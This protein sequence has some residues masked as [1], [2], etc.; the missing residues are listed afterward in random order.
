MRVAPRRIFGE[1]V[2]A[3]VVASMVFSSWALRLAYEGLRSGM[4]LSSEAAISVVL[5][6]SYSRCCSFHGL[7]AHRSGHFWATLQ[8][9]HSTWY[10][11]L[12]VSATYQQRN[13]QISSAKSIAKV[14]L[15]VAASSACLRMGR[16]RQLSSARVSIGARV[17][18]RAA[19]QRWSGLCTHAASDDS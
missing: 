19:T 7:R 9:L 6:L 5:S 2:E 16:K 18:V 12:L 1:M 17:G 11:A 13:S 14:R 15:D 3:R 10:A 4:S 8:R